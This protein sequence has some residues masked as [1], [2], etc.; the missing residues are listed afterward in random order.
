M[1][2]VEDD[3]RAVGG[4]GE[5]LSSIGLENEALGNIA[6]LKVRQELPLFQVRDGDLFLPRVCNK[7]LS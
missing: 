6:G 7:D 5:E 1:E 3:K 4:G 2:S